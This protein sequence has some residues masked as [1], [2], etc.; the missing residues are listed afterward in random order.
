MTHNCSTLNLQPHVCI[1]I[2]YVERGSLSFIISFT[3]FFVETFGGAEIK[4]RRSEG[5]SGLS[6]SAYIYDFL[7]F[8]C[9]YC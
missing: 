4:R 5:T 6:T 2:F 8:S 3:N 7:D 9:V 1:A